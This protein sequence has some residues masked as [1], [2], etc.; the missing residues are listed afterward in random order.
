[1]L[2]AGASNAALQLR[3]PSMLLLLLLLLLCA[4]IIALSITAWSTHTI[5]SSCSHSCCSFCHC[6]GSAAAAVGEPTV[7][8]L[9]LLLQPRAAHCRLVC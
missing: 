1:M 2:P 8:L 4:D 7:L 5:P 6:L 9:Q 3:L